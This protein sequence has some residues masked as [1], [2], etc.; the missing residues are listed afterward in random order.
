LKEVFET[1]I[2]A[3]RPRRIPIS[4]NANATTINGF[5]ETSRATGSRHGG[6]QVIWINEADTITATKP[7]FRQIELKLKKAAGL[8]YLTSEMMDDA[9]V[10]ESECKSAFVS[11]MGFAI[12]D[13]MIN[14]T[15]GAEPLG[16]LNAG[17]LVTVPKE[18]GQKK[19]TVIAESL[20]IKTFCHN[21]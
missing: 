19:E 11:E 20:S 21:F 17:S 3:A 10:L 16:I 4:G 13:V 9:S 15:G 5:D 1:G 7:K 6:V 18:T 2:L 14:G 12:D 8:V